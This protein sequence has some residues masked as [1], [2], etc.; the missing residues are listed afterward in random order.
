MPDTDFS[1]PGLGPLRAAAG[2]AM[3]AP[4]GSGLATADGAAS[5]AAARPRRSP[6]LLPAR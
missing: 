5:P 6:A 3:L 4:A 1:N 2:D